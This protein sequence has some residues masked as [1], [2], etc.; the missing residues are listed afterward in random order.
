MPSL[1]FAERCQEKPPQSHLYFGVRNSESLVRAPGVLRGISGYRRGKSTSEHSPAGL[2]PAG[3]RT[4]RWLSRTP[5]SADCRLRGT[6]L[7]LSNTREAEPS[8]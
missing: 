1:G 4:G 5:G 2:E 3:S 8:P 6:G 7:T